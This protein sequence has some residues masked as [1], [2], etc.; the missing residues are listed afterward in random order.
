MDG[1]KQGIVLL[2]S[3]GFDHEVSNEN[4]SF[5]SNSGTWEV[6]VAATAARNFL[7]NADATKVGIETNL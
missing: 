2:K 4:V 6:P 5:S 7:S 1:E 3:H